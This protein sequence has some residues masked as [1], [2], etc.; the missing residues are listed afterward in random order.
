M[1]LYVCH[2]HTR[3]HK[4]KNCTHPSLC[5]RNLF[6]YQFGYHSYVLFTKPALDLTLSFFYSQST[7]I[8]LIFIHCQRLPEDRKDTTLIWMTRYSFGSMQ[9]LSYFVLDCSVSELT[10]NLVFPASIIIVWVEL[11]I[12]RNCMLSSDAKRGQMLTIPRAV[13]KPH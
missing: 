1:I 10:T 3:L 2:M 13:S 7:C 4:K 12:V 6:I 5:T 11:V 9:D 8:H